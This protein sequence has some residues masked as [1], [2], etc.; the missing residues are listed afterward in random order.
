MGISD[1]EHILTIHRYP[2]H[3][4]DIRTGRGMCCGPHRATTTTT[5]CRQDE[6]GSGR[7]HHLHNKQHRTH[8]SLAETGLESNLGREE[9]GADELPG[10]SLARES[11]A[12][13]SP[14]GLP[15]TPTA[16]ALTQSLTHLPVRQNHASEGVLCVPHAMWCHAAHIPSMPPRMASVAFAVPWFGWLADTVHAWRLRSGTESRHITSRSR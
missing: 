1:S 16:S 7:L 14:P 15:R 8:S 11:A 13:R 5:G 4:P 10:R 12:N 2:Q 3:C 9:C 6:K